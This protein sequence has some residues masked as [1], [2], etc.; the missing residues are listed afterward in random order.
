LS[1]DRAGRTYAKARAAQR[2][3]SVKVTS[4][5]GSDDASLGGASLSTAASNVSAATLE[6]V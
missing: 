5:C 2:N 4:A 3:P 1:N 6:S